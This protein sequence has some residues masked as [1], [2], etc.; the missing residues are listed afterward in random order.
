M[1]AVD[2][3]KLMRTRFRGNAAVSPVAGYP[4]EAVN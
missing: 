1:P 2:L 4:V 3:W